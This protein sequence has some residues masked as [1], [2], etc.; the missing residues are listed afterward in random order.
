MGPAI[1]Y[2]VNVTNTGSTDADDVV[3]G[4][5]TPPGAG[6]D[7]VAL[8]TLFGFERV[9]VKAGETVS[10]NLYPQL[11]DFAHVDLSGDRAALPGEYRVAFGVAAAASQGMGYA[12]AT[13]LASDEVEYI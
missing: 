7:G 5:L 13:L 10:V 3:L 1:Q 2:T 11:T 12:E 6:K 9:H 4:F 8:Q